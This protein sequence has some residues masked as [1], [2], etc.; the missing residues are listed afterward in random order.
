MASDIGGIDFSS[1]IHRADSASNRSIERISS[2]SRLNNA[3]DGAADVSISNRFSSQIRAFAQ[4]ARNASD[5]VSLVQ[6]A[7]GSLEA[8]SDNLQRLRELALQASNGPLNT[9]DLQSLNKEAQQLKDEVSR[10]TRT[11]QFNNVPVL[12][13]PREVTVQLGASEADR[14]QLQT[15]DLDN[16]LLEL[17]FDRI[18]LSSREGANAA[19]S[20][21]DNTQLEVVTGQTQL[22]AVINR[23]EASINTL[24]EGRE[25][26]TRAQSRVSDA[27]IAK[28]VSELTRNEIKKEVSIAM[29]TQANQQGEV[30]LQ[31]LS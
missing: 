22:G 5:A 27:D 14:I 24:G 15:L 7:S 30:V 6:V 3:G 31:L 26:T 20:I 28:E 2:G 18:D 4:S 21:I 25:N 12:S 17:D 11:S 8:V 13:E 29:Q 23:F 19:L 9:S 16:R 10:V 1:Q